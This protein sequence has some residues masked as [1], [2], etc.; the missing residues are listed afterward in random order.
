MKSVS[1]GVFHEVVNTTELATGKPTNLFVDIPALPTNCQQI[2]FLG[3]V[4]ALKK[5]C[6]S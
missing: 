4:R 1:N 5:F 3:T 2:P 6:S